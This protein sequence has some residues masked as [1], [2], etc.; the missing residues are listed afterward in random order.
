LPSSAIEYGLSRVA[1]EAKSGVWKDGD[2]ADGI[3]MW[4]TVRDGLIQNNNISGKLQGI[5][6]FG[7]PGP[8]YH[9]R[10]WLINNAVSLE[11]NQGIKI[12]VSRG[13]TRGNSVSGVTTDQKNK[14]QFDVFGDGTITCENSA[15]GKGLLVGIGSKHAQNCSQVTMPTHPTPPLGVA[16]TPITTT[17]PPQTTDP[18]E[19]VFLPLTPVPPVENPIKDLVVAERPIQPVTVTE[20]LNKL[21]P[22]DFSKTL[23]PGARGE[24]VTGLQMF[25]QRLGYYNYPEFTTFYGTLTTQA[26]KNFQ[27]ANSLEQVGAVGPK[28]RALIESNKDAVVENSVPVLSQTQPTVTALPP[29]LE[30]SSLSDVISLQRFLNQNGFTITQTGPGS[31]G[32]ENGVFGPATQNALKRFQG[33]YSLPVTGRYDTQT[34]EKVRE[35]R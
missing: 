8:S 11:N 2:H 21:K 27:N 5:S 32:R 14:V 29:V 15:T 34:R 10:L 33:F 35:L 25:L 9:E 17:T 20:A 18:R 12:E 28:T 26:V 1:C 13:F 6:T 19:L 3:Q 23:A 22:I 31:K 24:H 16:P 4:N 30:T 7:P